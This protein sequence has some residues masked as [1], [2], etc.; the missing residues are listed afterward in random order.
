MY[1]AY[2]NASFE[3]RHIICTF[4]LFLSTKTIEHVERKCRCGVE[5]WIK[6]TKQL[7]FMT[8]CR[9]SRDIIV[10]GSFF[11]ISLTI[12]IFYVSGFKWGIGKSYAWN[13]IH[14]RIIFTESRQVFSNKKL[15]VHYLRT[16][17]PT[18]LFKLL[19]S[20]IFAVEF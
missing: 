18:A 5:N 11:S 7:L 3:N 9:V 2:E 14:A 13:L 16:C 8:P 17:I 1:C 10:T 4:Y 20:I 15:P 6:Q 19:L 12:K